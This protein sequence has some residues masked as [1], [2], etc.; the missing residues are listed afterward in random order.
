MGPRRRRNGSLFTFATI[1][2]T[3]STHSLCQYTPTIALSSSPVQTT[4]R[5]AVDTKWIHHSPRIRTICHA[6]LKKVASSFDLDEILSIE[7]EL[8]TARDDD[9]GPSKKK[10]RRN[11]K[12]NDMKQKMK[13]KMKKERQEKQRVQQQMKMGSDGIEEDI[14]D[15][16]SD[17]DYQ[18]LMESIGFSAY[19]IP[20]DLDGK[21]IDAVLVELLNKKDGAD[22]S[23]T[24]GS[25]PNSICISRSQ[26]GTLLSNKCV[27]V[28][29]AEKSNQFLS[30]LESNRNEVGADGSTGVPYSLVERFSSPIQRKSH[31]LETSSILLHP[32]RESLLSVSSSA[33][34]L[35]NLI[36][37]TEIIA[38][39]IPLD[40]LY[41]DEHM[42]VLNKRA[43]MV[44]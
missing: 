13:E 39:K 33:T 16:T 22:D 26:C 38:Q 30:A 27:F 8:D 5:M 10:G 11:P 42:I 37:P 28:V 9:V 35:S 40:V 34:L 19:K 24:L 20:S 18:A 32:S 1:A 44:V 23:S 31:P 7:K 15:D 36:P 21:R 43:G 29:A 17:V 4:V 6:K 3:C 25:T 41:E 12:K 14:D 2:S